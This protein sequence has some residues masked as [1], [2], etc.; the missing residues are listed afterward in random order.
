[1]LNT[2]YPPRKAREGLF[3]VAVTLSVSF[4]LLPAHAAPDNFAAR[5]LPALLA[6]ADALPPAGLYTLAARLFADGRRVEAVRWLY[7]AQI[8]AHYRLATAPDL[9]EDGE[10]ALY[11]SLQDTVGRPINEWAFGDVPAL[12]ARMQEALDWDAAHPPQPVPR[13]AD[14]QAWQQVRDGLAKLRTEVLAQA[15]D[16]R[17]QRSANGLPNR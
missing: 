11:A 9:P 4:G 2:A 6:Q 16:I 5:P 7:V 17:R 3:A 15:T 14:H 12:G 13:G 10:P 8:R 1:M